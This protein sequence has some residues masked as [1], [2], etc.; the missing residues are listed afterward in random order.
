VSLWAR[1]ASRLALAELWRTGRLGRRLGQADAWDELARLPWTRRTSR[2]DELALDVEHRADVETLLDRAW[3]T[4]RE[5][6]A[7]LDALDLPVDPTGWRRLGDLERQGALGSLPELPGRLNVRTATAAVAPHSKASLSDARLEG[8]GDVD[9][10]RDGVLRLRPSPGLLLVHGALSFAADALATVLGEVTISERAFRD[11]TRLAGAPPRALLLVENKGTFVDLTPPDGWL[12][13]HVPGWDTA[14]VTDLLAQVPDVP[15]VHFG[16]LDPNGV[17]I[18]RH[19]RA[20][21]PRLR[22]A[23]PAFWRE[24]VP[25]RALPRPWPDDLPLDDAPALVRD[26]AARGLWLEQELLALDP[27]LGPALEDAL[28]PSPR[29]DGEAPPCRDAAGPPRAVDG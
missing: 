16:D 7:R 10:T 15:V 23:V 17:R 5:D 29:P 14:S 3:P 4:W 22:W 9:L 8:L 2:R 21:C 12:V 13:A 1:D 6:L 20:L 26:L 25:A 24:H 18:V 19:L 11:G 28:A 27:R